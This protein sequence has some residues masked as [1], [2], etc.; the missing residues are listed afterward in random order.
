MYSSEIPTK[1]QGML[2]HPL[3]L[4]NLAYQ[5]PGSSSCSLLP[6]ALFCRLVCFASF[7]WLSETSLLSSFSGLEGDLTRKPFVWVSRQN[8][9]RDHLT[10]TPTHTHTE[11]RM[12]SIVS[13]GFCL[14]LLEWSFPRNKSK[15]KRKSTTERL[16]S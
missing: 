15:I 3:T 7:S 10:G 13:H 11:K 1:S 14:S 6:T 4:A 2:T 8:R 16:P 12:P 9:Q 5:S